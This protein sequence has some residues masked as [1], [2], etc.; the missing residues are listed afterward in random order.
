LFAHI[1]AAT[2]TAVV[3]TNNH[4]FIFGRHTIMHN[5]VV[6]HFADIRRAMLDVLEKSAY[7][8]IRGTTDS[9]HFAA[10]Y[11]T[12]L[13]RSV[14]GGVQSWERQYTV[15]EM[16]HALVAASKT[17]VEIQQKVMGPEN[18]MAN[19]L[20]VCVTDGVQMVAVR[21]RNH[22]IE[23]PPSLYWSTTAGITLNRKYPDLPSG[24]TN[25]QAS[26]KKSEHG[27]HVIVASEPT[28]HKAGEW[29][30]IEKNHALVV[31]A[32]GNCELVAAPIPE[33]LLAQAATGQ[34]F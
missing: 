29:T 22:A 24:G 4:P 12:Y 9:E 31:D 26:K 3:P 25:E 16:K 17:V 28:T 21:H 27:K 20:N 5:G 34:H 11:M 14:G 6:A 19:S 7:E 2:A 15:D 33:G 8:N 32:D 10:L 1:R 13:T 30:L 23:Q 18:V